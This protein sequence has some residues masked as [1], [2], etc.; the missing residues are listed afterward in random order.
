MRQ[1]HVWS[2]AP[3]SVEA[4]LGSLRGV[5]D[6]DELRRADRLRRDADRYA[7]T[8]AHT[9][10]RHALSELDG[11]RPPEAWVFDRGPEGRPHLVADPAATEG[12]AVTGE[13]RL[14]FSLSH[15]RD[16]VACA[17]GIGVRCGVDVERVRELSDLASLE[18][19]VLSEV[20]RESLARLRDEARLESFYRFWT[21]KEAWGKATGV[22]I[23]LPLDRLVFSVDHH[24]AVRLVSTPEPDEATSSAAALVSSGDDHWTFRSRTTGAGAVVE[25]IAGWT[26]DAGEPPEVVRHD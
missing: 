16:W 26:G 19:R 24:D 9:L 7:W 18:E 17:V 12:S 2:L 22:G 15:T 11:S 10:L 23:L 1:I 6:A 20:E 21:L 3:A 14:D 25:A 5:L 8:A 13:R 4:R